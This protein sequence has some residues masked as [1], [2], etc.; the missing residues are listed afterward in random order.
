[1]NGA[2]LPDSRKGSHTPITRANAIALTRRNG[3]AHT[4]YT[5]LESLRNFGLQVKFPPSAT[6][7]R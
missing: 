5:N 6:Y 3:T 1:M 2:A 7:F 4:K